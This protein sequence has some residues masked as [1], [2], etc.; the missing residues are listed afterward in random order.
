MLLQE[1]GRAAR[2]QADRPRR[3][4]GVPDREPR[5]LEEARELH[6]EPRGR[7]GAGRAPP[8]RRDPGAGR[9]GARRP[10]RDRGH[11]RGG[12]AGVRRLLII[13][14]VAAGAAALGLAGRWAWEASLSSPR[15]AIADIQV[16][17]THR[18]AA[19]SIIAA[20]GVV[21]G[22]N[23]L[24]LDPKAVERRLARHPWVAAARVQRHLPGT[25]AIRV[26]EREPV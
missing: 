18:V 21:A 6:R 2:E 12:G 16:A 25:V 3:A 26:V 9:E 5:G 22:T 17:G 1:P 4:Q 10:H 23:I 7:D 11:D 14:L 15:L 24:R 20:S 19:D 13:G 8:G